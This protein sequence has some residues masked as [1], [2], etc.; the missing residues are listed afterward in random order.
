MTSAKFCPNCGFKLDGTEKFCPKCGFDLT[1][2]AK[3]GSV[4]IEARAAVVAGQL[5]RLTL[6]R[7]HFIVA[8]TFLKNNALTLFVLFILM[9]FLPL[10]GLWRLSLFVTYLAFVY[11][12]PLLTG[13][14]RVAWDEKLDD[15]L[16]DKNNLKQLNANLSKGLHQ[17]HH[18]SPKANE[19]AHPEIENRIHLSQA[20]QPLSAASTGNGFQVNAE[21][22]MG[23][24]ALIAG[25]FMYQIGKQSVGSLSSQAISLFQSGSLSTSGYLYIWGVCLLGIGVAMTL[26]GLIKG[27]R[28][29][30]KGGGLLKFFGVVICIGTAIAATYVYANPVSTSLRAA[31]AA[32]NSGMNYSDIQNL[33]GVIKALPYVAAIIYG[34]GI[35]VNATRYRQS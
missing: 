10:G 22:I 5:S 9:T 2:N 6:K 32:Y 12:Y 14:K 3:N 11:C 31:E 17:L 24:V 29:Q 33:I 8:L 30:L 20:D 19:N 28:R 23:I 35:F 21:L 16:Q 13:K 25:F 15:W 18:A 1:G 34:L 26:G 4:K 27:I 7:E